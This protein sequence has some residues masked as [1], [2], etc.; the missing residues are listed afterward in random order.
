VTPTKMRT[1]TPIEIPTKRLVG[2]RTMW[3]LFQR[4]TEV[5][6]HRVEWPVCLIRCFVLGEFLDAN[7]KEAGDERHGQ[8]CRINNWF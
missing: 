2:Y 3:G 8:L 6:R 4:L 1:E 5:A 7:G